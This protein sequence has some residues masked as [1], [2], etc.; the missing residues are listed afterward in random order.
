M[1]CKLLRHSYNKLS[2]EILEI[3]KNDLT[4]VI[5]KIVL[6]ILLSLLYAVYVTEFLKSVS[7][8]FNFEKIMYLYL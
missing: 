6:K 1:C 2:V 4:E 8:H 5:C 3:L 7:K